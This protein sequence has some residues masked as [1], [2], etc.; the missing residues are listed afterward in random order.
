MESEYGVA[1]SPPATTSSPP[2]PANG[3]P[4]DQKRD[5]RYRNLLKIITLPLVSLSRPLLRRFHSVSHPSLLAVVTFAIKTSGLLA[6]KQRCSL[7]LLW[8]AIQLL[9]A[10]HL[11]PLRNLKKWTPLRQTTDLFQVIVCTP[12]PDSLFKKFINREGDK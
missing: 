11:L 4:P 10:S 5:G 9:S 3:N 8:P 6:L 7:P 12:I 2:I 1:T